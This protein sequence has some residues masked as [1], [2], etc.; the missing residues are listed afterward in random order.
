MD[1]LAELWP[2]V[3]NN[4]DY[5]IQIG[6]E[7]E[8]SSSATLWIGFCVDGINIELFNVTKNQTA[9]KIPPR[10]RKYICGIDIFDPINSPPYFLMTRS[11]YIY[12]PCY[13]VVAKRCIPK[14]DPYNYN[15]DSI[16]LPSSKLI[17]YAEN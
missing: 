2:I 12:L 3:K 15:P 9:I 5:S 16:Y 11:I 8:I 10:I 4:I 13:Q 1:I 7:E 6:Y 17:K 14:L